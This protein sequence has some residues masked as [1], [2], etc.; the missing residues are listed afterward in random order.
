M[1][2]EM[3]NALTDDVVVRHEG[4]LDTECPRHHR[5]DPLHPLEQR[6]HL[7]GMQI[8]QG[9]DVA[10]RNNQ[11]VATKQRRPIEKDNRFIVLPDDVG[12]QL[13]GNDLTKRADWLRRH[14]LFILSSSNWTLSIH[15]STR[16]VLYN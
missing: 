10:S 6:A 14:H 13:P 1:D 2:V 15:Q 12:S 9:D 16:V 4:A 7:A 3:R 11:R 8:R 5:R